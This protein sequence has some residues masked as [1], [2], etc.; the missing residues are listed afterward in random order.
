[1]HL[2]DHNHE[3]QEASFIGIQIASKT[4][5]R[6]HL[7][8][9]NTMETG[10]VGLSNEGDPNTWPSFDLIVL[11]VHAMNFVDAAVFE[12]GLVE[13]LP[14]NALIYLQL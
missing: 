4:I 3:L 13:N 2:L 7:G 8:K 14:A 1:M 6:I 9:I 11:S 12:G 5:S 10:K